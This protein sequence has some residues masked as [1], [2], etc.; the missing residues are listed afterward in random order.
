MRTFNEG[1]IITIKLISGEEVIS[2]Y[3]SQTETSFEVSK[4]YILA[5]MQQGIGL[6]P[7][8]LTG[9]ESESINIGTH[10][11]VAVTISDDDMRKQY[12]ETTSSILLP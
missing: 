10:G 11:V 7:Y 2:K 1:D 8:I 3:I 4:P 5:G 6:A 9:Q 12:I